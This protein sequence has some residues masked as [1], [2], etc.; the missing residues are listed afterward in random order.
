MKKLPAWLQII[1][2]ITLPLLIFLIIINVYLR[3]SSP[4]FSSPP[5]QSPSTSI[6][7]E[8]VSISTESADNL[9]SNQNGG[10][11]KTLA[12]FTPI[13]ATS[14][15]IS[16]NRG[17]IKV[18]LYPDKVPLTVTN[19]LTLA[20]EG[21]YDN[22]KF[23]RVIDNFM[24][25]AGDP[26]SR[27]EKNTSLVGTGGPDYRIEDEFDE[28]LIHDSAGILSMANTGQPHTGGSQFF[29]TFEPTPW[30]DGQ[31]AVFGKVADEQSLR[32]L[33]SIKQ[34]DVIFS[35]TF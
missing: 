26:N 19:F 8:E 31:H 21:F 11:V 3:L 34:G 30:L 16:T 29:I 20:Q 15:V 10:A 23:H 32:V 22:I 9:S 24:A 5:S 27:D 6:N 28:S 7:N 17:N 12:D 18:D 2:L 35:I 33:Q 1:L 14:A 4:D 25:Q 13:N